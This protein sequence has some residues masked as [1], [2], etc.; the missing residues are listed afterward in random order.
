MSFAEGTLWSEPGAGTEAIGTAIAGDVAVEVF[1]A[2]HF[3]EVV[4]RWTCSVA[5]IDDPD[6]GE[7]LGIIDLTGE[8]SDVHPHSLAVASGDGAAVEAMLRLEMQEHDLRL[9]A[10]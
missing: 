5:P 2:E 3:S 1:G 4:Q 10:R 8:F 7:L 9:R 6:S